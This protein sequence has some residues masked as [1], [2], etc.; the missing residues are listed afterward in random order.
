MKQNVACGVTNIPDRKPLEQFAPPRLSLLTI[1]KP[2]PE[3]LQLDD[4]QR[5]LNAQD[6]LVVEVIQ[7][8]NLLLISDERAKNLADL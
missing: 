8:I 7:I 6:Q 5:S 4:T 1:L 3:D 2:L